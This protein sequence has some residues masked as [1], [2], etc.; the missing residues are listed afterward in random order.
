MAHAAARG[1]SPTDIA[2]RLQEGSLREGSQ[3]GRR[4]RDAFVAGTEVGGERSTPVIVCCGCRGTHLPGANRAAEVRMDFGAICSSPSYSFD[5][6]DLPALA[7][8]LALS[9][10]QFAQASLQSPTAYSGSW[11]NKLTLCIMPNGRLCRGGCVPGSAPSQKLEVYIG[12]AQGLTASR[13]LTEQ[14]HA[15]SPP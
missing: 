13:S 10:L 7:R 12:L 1:S 15:R 14:I 11:S 4:A 2:E 5:S 6:G 8:R 3:Y 9:A